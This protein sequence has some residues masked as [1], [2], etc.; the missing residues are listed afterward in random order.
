MLLRLIPD[1]PLPTVLFTLAFQ[2]LPDHVPFPVNWTNQLQHVLQDDLE[3]PNCV[4]ALDRSAWAISLLHE[5]NFVVPARM[6]SCLFV[7]GTRAEW[8]ISDERCLG[9]LL[10][11][12]GDVSESAE[13][14]EMEQNRAKALAMPPMT[15]PASPAK[16]Y[17]HKKSRSILM[18]LVASLVPMSQ[19]SSPTLPP[20]EPP[21]PVVLPPEPRISSRFLRRRARASLVDVYRRYILPELESPFPRGGYVF[22]VMQSMMRRINARMQEL[23]QEMGGHVPGGRLRSTP[24][25]VRLRISPSALSESP[26][27]DDESSSSSADTDGSSVHTPRDSIAEY[28]VLCRAASS[29]DALINAENGLIAPM[30]TST[31]PRSRSYEGALSQQQSQQPQQEGPLAE[32]TA[33]HTSTVRLRAMLTRTE[34]IENGMASDRAASLAILEVKSKRRA[35][36]SHALLGGSNVAQAGLG[37]PLRSSPLARCA[38]HTPESLAA[39]VFGGARR[40]LGTIRESDGFPLDVGADGDVALFVPSQGG[41]PFPQTESLDDFCST[42]PQDTLP[43]FAHPSDEYIEPSRITA[44]CSSDNLPGLLAAEQYAHSPMP[45][46]RADPPAVPF[47]VFS[48]ACV[49]DPATDRGCD[50]FTLS[51]DLHAY[52]SPRRHTPKGGAGRFVRDDWMAEPALDCR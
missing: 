28:P 51:L 21:A 48:D 26:F 7:D 52:A 20:Y 8:P 34:S 30:T 32:Y 15:R 10:S 4:H 36:S 49:F 23:V 38:V 31:P 25:R 40:K 18:T 9:A 35:W 2:N 41:I 19:P 13:A 37:M 33:L 24:S 50:E 22:W 39:G 3:M 6:I 27:E 17:K 16:P 29:D 44:S 11:V 1:A 46:R 5:V 14:L 45:I 47:D 12:V 42:G 43:L